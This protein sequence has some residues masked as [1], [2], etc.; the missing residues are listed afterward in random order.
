[1]WSNPRIYYCISFL[2]GQAYI[3]QL[4]FWRVECF[5]DGNISVILMSISH[6]RALDVSQI[7]A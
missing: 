7:Q 4:H 2:E 5:L 6:Y 1:M 3:E